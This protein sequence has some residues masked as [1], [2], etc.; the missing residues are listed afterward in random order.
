MKYA[1][2]A[3]QNFY[4]SGGWDDFIGFFPSLAEAYKR[5]SE[6]VLRSWVDTTDEFFDP[7]DEDNY[8]AFEWGHL[9]DMEENKVVKRVMRKWVKPGLYK[10][11]ET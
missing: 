1:L 10:I 2:F 8:E 11:V 9:V 3:G 6:P 7:N 4:P 5:F